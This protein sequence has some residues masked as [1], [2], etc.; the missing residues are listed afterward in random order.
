MN[1]SQSQT[2][3]VK[4]LSGFVLVNYQKRSTE[5]LIRLV[6]SLFLSI[7]VF[8]LSQI[9]GIPA[10]IQNPQFDLVVPIASTLIFII[11]GWPFF[12]GAITEFANK[13]PSMLSLISL[14]ITVSFA[15]ST[16]A[17]VMD[18]VYR[19]NVVSYYWEFALLIDVMLIGYFLEASTLEKA[20]NNFASVKNLLPKKALLI[21]T[22][23]TTK[24]ILVDDIQVGNLILV[25]ANTEIPADGVVVLGSSEVD[26]S[27]LSGE[28]NHVIKTIN[29]RVIGGSM[30]GNSELRIR[31]SHVG[32]DSYISQINHLSETAKNDV[33]DAENLAD[34]AST[35]LFYA[36]IA[37]AILTF[38]GWFFF[39]K[40]L[41]PAVQMAINVIVIASPYALGLAIPL[42]V[43]H[44]TSIG[45]KNNIL[46]KNQRAGQYIEEVAFAVFDKTGTLT[47][48]RFSVVDYKSMD[49]KYSA[50]KVLQYFASV[51]KNSSHP[52]ATSLNSYAKDHGIQILKT[53]D[54]TNVPGI[55]AIATV[56]DDGI[57][58]TARITNFK[59]LNSM[60]KYKG[61][62]EKFEDYTIS[63]LLLNDELAGFVT[64]TDKV[65]DDASSL[66]ARFSFAQV[67]TILM[68]GDN[69]FVANKVAA[70]LKI[71]QVFSGLLPDQKLTVIKDLQNAGHRVLMVG[72]GVND[73]PSIAQ[74]DIGISFSNGTD[75]A[76]NAADVILLDENLNGIEKYIRFTDTTKRKINQNI[77]IGIVYNI[78][79]IPLAA[80][81]LAPFGFRLTPVIAAILMLVSVIAVA[82]NSMKMKESI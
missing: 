81:I 27:L 39:T 79:A 28:S 38:L 55:G 26:E 46:I 9:L 10:L 29:D 56:F 70:L 25:P 66:I 48:G 45:I 77:L 80:G 58:Y 2:S 23:A 49:E 82:L 44:S 74:A 13:R 41:A 40:D 22:D 19:Q 30:N 37:I 78:I 35:F 53:K 51:E 33:S 71:D 60:P 15:Y 20:T 12:A 5:F 47:D 64:F 72:D 7:P 32:D 52:L 42:V 43:A 8:L 50:D 16:Y 69:R 54:F 1:N 14:G 63:Y 73:A 34:K 65:R 61:R 36:A 11:G 68:T 3:N 67:T 75:L 21:D 17:F 18:Y 24:E 4:K 76:Q 31:V 6:I 57:S 59:T 62:I